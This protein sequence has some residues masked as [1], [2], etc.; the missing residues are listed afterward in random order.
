MRVKTPFDFIIMKSKK[1]TLFAD[2]KTTEGNTFSH[3][4]I[5][6]HQ[7]AELLKIEAIGGTAGYIVFFRQ[8]SEVVWFSAGTLKRLLP[9]ASL[10]A[11]EGETLG[12]FHSFGFN[13]LFVGI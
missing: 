1:E 6:P 10:K 11:L 5:T 2:A 3:S 13:R 9:G 7:L 4:K 8:S 12:S